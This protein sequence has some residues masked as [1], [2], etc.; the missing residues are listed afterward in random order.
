MAR[1]PI[2]RRR[3]PRRRRARS[4]EAADAELEAELDA[5]R[6]RARDRLRAASGPRCCSRASTTSGRDPDRSAPAPAAPRRPTGPRCSCGC[7]CAG[8]S[9]TASTTEILDQQEGE[10]AGPQERDRRGQR[11]PG[12]R[13]A[14]RRARRPPARPDQPVRL[15]R[16]GARRRSPSSRS[17]PEVDDDVEIELDWDEIRVDTFRSQGAGGQ[18]V[19][20]TDSAVRLTHLPTGIVAQS[21]NERS[22]TQNKE[23][24]IKVLKA[25]LLERAARGEGGR[26]ARRSR[27]STW[28]PAGAT[29]SGATCCTRTRW[30]RTCAPNYETS[31]TAA[32]L[33]GDLDAFMQA[34]LE[35]L[36]SAA[37]RTRREPSEAVASRAG[38][39]DLPSGP[40]RRAAG[41]RRD[42][43][44]VDQRLH[45]PPRAARDRVGDEPAPAPVR[46]PVHH[47]PRSVRRGDRGR[48]DARSER[49]VGVRVGA[50]PRAAVVPVDAV[51]LARRPGGRGRPGAAGAG[52]ARAAPTGMSHGD[53]DGQRAADLQ[54]ALLH[55]T[56]SCP[57]SRSST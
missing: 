40:P 12:V 10:Q 22:Q 3:P 26:A 4:T 2:A 47:G 32:V 7:T 18:H 50:R 15:P 27:A 34:E 6:R 48:R 36:A 39:A 8:P 28:R 14:A 13:L 57:G 56:G 45:R 17:C 21:Q 1:S 20:K 38:R 53:R 42:L 31:N 41:L 37:T 16:T 23:M 29:R 9:G 52:H 44:R 5:R 33:D 35:R 55:A 24:A 51:R 25:R 49:I 54:R 30:S 11:P 19:N 46:P 43:A